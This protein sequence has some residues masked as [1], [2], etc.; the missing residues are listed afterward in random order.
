MNKTRNTELIEKYLY[1]E[2]T[3]GE[4]ADFERKVSRD[5]GLAEELKLHEELLE[6]I[7]DTGKINLRN[8][9]VQIHHKSTSIRLLPAFSTKIRSIAAIIILFLVVGGLL[10]TNYLTLGVSDKTIYSHYFDPEDALF[11]VRSANETATF[12]EEGMK[13]YQQRDYSGAI[14]AFSLEPDNLLG[15]LYSGFSLMQIGR[16]D[17]A[18]DY[19]LLILEDNDNLL[20]DQAEWNLGLCYLMTGERDKAKSMFQK[21]AAGNTVYNE[22]ALELLTKLDKID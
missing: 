6:A 20:L 13:L 16:F 9:L 14:T 1:Q 19:F 15:K 4:K 5:P 7:N 11:T 17:Q 21:I 18:Q 10:I 8:T 3:A 2:M 12:V 22:K